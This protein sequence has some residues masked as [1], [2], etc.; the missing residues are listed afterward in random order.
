MTDVRQEAEQQHYRTAVDLLQRCATNPANPQTGRCGQYLAKLRATG[1]P[2][3]AALAQSWAQERAGLQEKERAQ[4][5]ANLRASS[6]PWEKL[7]LFSD[8][9][10][11]AIQPIRE[12]EAQQVGA[13]AFVAL[14]EC[15]ALVDPTCMAVYGDLILRGAEGLAPQE[16]DRARR[17][18]VH[19]LKQA[20]RHGDEPSRAALATLGEEAPASELAP[21]LTIEPLRPDAA[22]DPEAAKRLALHRQ[23]IRDYRALGETRRRAELPVWSE[24]FSKFVCE[25]PGAGEAQIYTRCW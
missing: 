7:L 23:A 5:A 12:D 25:K 1:L 11:G 4:R 16:R 10:A 9:C 6:D 2:L 19:W 3:E 22:G 15:A 24:L 18:A 14:G 17:R 8:L 21:D 20:A 13:D